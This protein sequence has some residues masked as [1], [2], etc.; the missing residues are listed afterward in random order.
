MSNTLLRQ[1][2][3]LGISLSL[4]LILLQMWQTELYFQRQLIQSGEIWR[5]WTGNLV[6]TN[7]WHVALNV[8]GWGVLL[9]LAPNSLTTRYLMLC[10]MLLMLIVGGGLYSFNPNLVWYAGFSGVLYG[11]FT[12]TGLYWLLEEDYVLGLM[13]LLFS[14]GK[15]FSDLAL[16]GDSLSSQL[17]AAPVVYAA[18]IYGIL[19]GV[20]LAIPQVMRSLQHAAKPA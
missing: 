3:I 6:H 19:G 16:G 11:L 18:H 14:G 12:L 13:L 1:R 7:Y 15:A 9:L 10:I 17:I 2:W 4:V 8:S 5:L 20:G